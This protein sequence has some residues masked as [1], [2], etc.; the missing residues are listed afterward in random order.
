ML[1][2]KKTTDKL[3]DP[4]GPAWCLWRIQGSEAVSP[5]QGR[6]WSSV[7]HLHRSDQRNGGRPQK[8]V[9]VKSNASYG[10]ARASHHFAFWLWASPRPWVAFK[11]MLEGYGLWA[12]HPSSP[13]F[14]WSKPFKPSNYPE[15]ENSPTIILGGNHPFLS[16]NCED[17]GGLSIANLEVVTRSGSHSERLAKAHRELPRLPRSLRKGA[18]SQLGFGTSNSP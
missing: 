14:G 4:Q 8:C 11:M 3:R 17:P 5:P 7:G 1:S 18:T 12:K 10:K 15:Q 2:E 13:P 16:W 9:Q 6:A